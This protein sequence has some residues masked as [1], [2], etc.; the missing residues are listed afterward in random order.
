M[1]VARAIT[2]RLLGGGQIIDWGR[3]PYGAAAAIGRTPRVHYAMPM[4]L[5]GVVID[6]SD[7]PQGALDA[8][9]ASGTRRQRSIKALIRRRTRRC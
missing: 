9:A 7:T 3:A 1:S 2:P 6:W 4:L 5:R 8:I